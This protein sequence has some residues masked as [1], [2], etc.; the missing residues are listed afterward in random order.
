M[1]GFFWGVCY[2]YEVTYRGMWLLRS[3]SVSVRT[4]DLSTARTDSK[5]SRYLV[6]TLPTSAYYLQGKVN[7]TL[8]GLNKALVRDLTSLAT[9]GIET[10]DGVSCLPQK[11]ILLWCTTEVQFRIPALELSGPLLHHCCLPRG[12]QVSQAGLQPAEACQQRASSSI[13]SPRLW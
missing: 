13:A 7:V 11:K 2:T 5:A 3:S 10:D 6:Y 4:P 1:L 12:P 8:Q 9:T